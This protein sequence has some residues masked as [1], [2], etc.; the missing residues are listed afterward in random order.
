[1]LK[2]QP[3]DAGVI[4]AARKD[5]TVLV[6]FTAAWC[7]ECLVV[8][9]KIYEDPDVVARLSADGVLAVKGDVTRSE[10]PATRMLYEQLGQAGPPLTA[11]F[12]R[13]GA[14]PILLLGSFSRDDLFKA[15]DMAA[16]RR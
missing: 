10:M 7:V 8:E 2:M 3:F 13:G 6:K 11:V 9:Q 14:P 1:M 15:L 4:A 16:G 12:P 5:R